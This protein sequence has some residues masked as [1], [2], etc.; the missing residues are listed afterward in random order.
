[1]YSCAFNVCFHYCGYSYSAYIHKCH[2]LMMINACSFRI[3]GSLQCKLTLIQISSSSFSPPTDVT[4]K[5]SDGSIDAH[6]M[7]LAAVSP[8]FERMFYG[9]VKEGKSVTVDLPKDSSETFKL[10]IDFVY[11]GRCEL[12]IPDDIFPLLE[13]FDRYQINKVP[14][15]HTCSEFILSDLD[16]SNYLVLLPKFASVMSEEGIRKAANKV[17]HYTSSDFI[18]KFDSTKDLPEEVL[19]Q[20]LQMDITNHEVDVFDFLVKWHDYQTKDLGRTLQ[21]THQLFCFVR[22]SLIIPQ[23]LSSRVVARCDLVN[24]QLIA[25]AYHY[26]YNSCKPLGEY[27]PNECTREPVSP[28]LRKPRCSLKLEWVSCQNG[29]TIN[30]G[31]LDKHS[32]SFSG[33]LVPVNNY[34][35]KSLS[36][37][38]GTYTF[39][40]LNITAYH[41]YNINCTVTR[42]SYSGAPISIA[43]CNQGDK[44]LYSYPLINSS[45]ITLYIHDDYLFLKLV[46]GDKVKSTTSIC[47]AGHFN[48]SISSLLP[49]NTSYH[50]EFHI[51]NHVQ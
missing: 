9:D 13:V 16:S 31:Q 12:K 24:N 49:Y 26:I 21:L 5:L 20:L 45:L 15:Y 51:H 38:N 2:H 40:V 34:I 7:I 28:S 41:T 27:D 11:C 36:L 46:E 25:D 14:F 35:T 10:L 42:Q 8:V 6:R 30:Y 44:Y 48:V 17:M 3:S 32:V 47:E 43:V 29:I 1:M 4:L 18:A 39:S 33:S 23:I 19:L 22:Y 50:C 37:R